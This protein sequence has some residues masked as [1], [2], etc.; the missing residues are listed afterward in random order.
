MVEHARDYGF[1][2]GQNSPLRTRTARFFSMAAEKVHEKAPNVTPNMITLLGV[3][4]VAAGG[5]IDERENRRENPRMFVKAGAVILK[6]TGDGMDGLDG[7]LKRHKK[8][9][10]TQNQ[11]MEPDF[12]PVIDILG[13]RA[14][15]LMLADMR[16]ETARQR[17]SKWGQFAAQAVE[18]TSILPSIVRAHINKNGGTP[19][20]V[21]NLPAF[22]GSRPGRIFLNELG[23]AF[24]RMQ[25]VIDLGATAANL[26]AVYHRLTAPGNGDLKQEERQ[27]AARVETALMVLQTAAVAHIVYRNRRNR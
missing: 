21:G 27:T 11:S 1:K 24:P 15:E 18:G 6:A 17:G 9:I 12:G 8:R 19:D 2:V 7:A 26:Y 23:A 20:E 22:F 4:L 16:E 5:Y 25:P 10:I 13:D 3:G 14:E